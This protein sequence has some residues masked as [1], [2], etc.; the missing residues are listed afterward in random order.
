MIDLRYRQARRTDIGR[1]PGFRIGDNSVGIDLGGGW[2][3]D[4]CENMS[5]SAPIALERGNCLGETIHG[6]G[7]ATPL[8]Q[9][10]VAANRAFIW[11]EKHYTLHFFGSFA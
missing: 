1:M 7:L 5:A 3:V 10:L 2:A 4:G 9:S 11:Y 8:L 6:N